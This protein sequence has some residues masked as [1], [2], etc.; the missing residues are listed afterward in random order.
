MVRMR[1]FPFGPCRMYILFSCMSHKKAIHCSLLGIIWEWKTVLMT[2]RAIKG[3]LYVC[4]LIMWITFCLWLSSVLVLSCR[5]L[6]IL[7]CHFVEMKIVKEM[8]WVTSNHWH[9]FGVS[10]NGCFCRLII[11]IKSLKLHLFNYD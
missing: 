6:S 8:K 1:I 2:F 3:S 11:L 10:K 9:F 5:V 7:L 4:F